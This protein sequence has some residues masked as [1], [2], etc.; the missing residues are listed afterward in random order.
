MSDAPDAPASDGPNTPD[1]PGA[2]SA[3]ASPAA[4]PGGGWR[5]PA[6]AA[7]MASVVAG[8]AGV[9]FGSILGG[10]GAGSAGP[11]TVSFAAASE[12]AGPTTPPPGAPGGVHC[13]PGR[14][15]R[16]RRG[17][18]GTVASVD[19]NRIS[20]TRGDGTKV[21]AVVS[22]STIYRR[23]AKGSTA[24]L[25]VGQG[26][27]A[28]GMSA[29]D[30]SVLARRIVVGPKDSLPS[31]MPGMS[32]RRP[33]GPFRRGTR[34]MGTITAVDGSNLTV[35]DASGQTHKV[36]ATPATRISKVTK[37][38]LSDVTP[39]TRVGVRGTRQSDGTV[40]AHGVT[41]LPAGQQPPAP[42][43]DV[44]TT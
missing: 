37:A 2:P 36:T 28:G 4:P 25:V 9:A 14:G 32:E 40:A 15:F 35:T 44:P 38:S 18:G 1:T 6:A 8:T 41:L 5:R 33:D 10:G 34:V 22:D 20:L 24:D 26:I 30:G 3:P 43:G 17:A 31:P 42:M 13:G 11:R 12:S 27:T 21:T 16:H 23:V 7:F 29:P 39:G 19:G